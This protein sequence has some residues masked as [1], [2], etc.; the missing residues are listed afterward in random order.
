MYMLYDEFGQ[1][2]RMVKTKHEAEYL[3][4][5]YTDWT[6]RYMKID[7]PPPLQLPEALF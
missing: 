5:T 2:I 1:P 7:P 4:K 6:Y 3:I